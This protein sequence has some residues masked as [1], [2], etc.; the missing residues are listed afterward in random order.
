MKSEYLNRVKRYLVNIPGWRTNRKIVVFE[1][2]DWGSIRMPSKDVYRKCL[3]AGYRVDQAPYE[4]Y[5]S[6]ASEDD[7][8]LLFDLLASFKDY[9]GNHPVITANALVANPDFHKIRE[10]NFEE[11]HYELITDTFKR[12]PNHSKCFELWKAGLE[13]GV[14][15][16]Q[17]HGR[18]HLNV[19]MFMKALQEGDEDVHFGFDHEMPGSIPKSRFNEG[20]RFVES[21]RYFDE[22]DKLHKLKIVEEGLALFEKLFGY[23]SES[24]IPPNYIW[25]PDYDQSISKKGVNFY[26]GNRIMIEPDL[27][28]SVRLRRHYLGEQNSFRQTYLVRNG[29]F[30]P[31]IQHYNVDDWISKCL[32]DIKTAFRMKKPAIICTHRLNYVGFIDNKNRDDTLRLLSSLIDIIIKNWPSVEF[33]NSEQ[34]GHLVN[35][36]SNSI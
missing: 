20:N 16:P 13:A 9:K 23:K 1:S 8:E 25:S 12:Y 2:D 22:E 7:L 28:K 33:F 27:N 26:Q 11:Y 29:L 36:N 5:D 4:R 10:S 21:L 17:S 18:E 6:L 19:S 32:N 31:S 30:E 35:E 14:F 24:F 34:L 15:Y 3:D